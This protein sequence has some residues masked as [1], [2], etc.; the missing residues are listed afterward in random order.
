MGRGMAYIRYK[1]AE[2][3]VATF[4]EVAVDP[5]SGEIA[6]TRVVCAHDGGLVVNPDALKNQIEGAIAQTLSRA[7]HEEVQFDTARVTSV[8]WASYPILRFPELPAIECLIDAAISRRG[9]ARKPPRC[10]PAALATRSSCHGVRLR[11]F[12]FTSARAGRPERP[13]PAPPRQSQAPHL[14]PLQI[15]NPNHVST[16]KGSSPYSRGLGLRF[17]IGFGSGLGE[18]DF[19]FFGAFRAQVKLF[20][21]FQAA[22]RDGS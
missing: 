21:T 12:P 13:V 3:Y 18:L 22:R 16:P 8:D 15:P 6:V 5:S 9:G 2:N 10:G 7:L 4:M 20:L 11:R 1:Q 14:P 17:G 19:D